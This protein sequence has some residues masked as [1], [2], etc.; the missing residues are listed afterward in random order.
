MHQLPTNQINVTEPRNL[1]SEHLDTFLYT[2]LR[3]TFCFMIKYLSIE[4]HVFNILPLS[5]KIHKQL[6]P[7]KLS[8]NQCKKNT[9]DEWDAIC[10][11]IKSICQCV[12]HIHGAIIIGHDVK[13]N[14]S[15]INTH[16]CFKMQMIKNNYQLNQFYIIFVK[17][18]IWRFYYYKVFI[19]CFGYSICFIFMEKI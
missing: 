6:G 12:V 8:M 2:L 5:N 4:E 13:L 15:M 19:R 3:D 9:F 14:P 17:C 16:Q 18:S 7:N 11:F 10:K 1:P